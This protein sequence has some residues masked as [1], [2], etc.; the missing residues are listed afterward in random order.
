MSGTVLSES[1][2]RSAPRRGGRKLKLLLAA[3]AVLAAA[4]TGTWYVAF[5]LPAERA[6][7]AFET[8]A[9]GVEQQQSGDLEAAIRSF[10]AA[11]RLDADNSRAWLLLGQAHR[12]RASDS[13]EGLKALERASALA[14]T[15][16]PVVREYGFALRQ[17]GRFEKARDVLRRVVA[18]DPTDAAAR[19]ELAQAHLGL[20]GSPE[21]LEAAI[22]ELRTGL[23]LEPGNARARYFLAR[24]L[25]QREQLPEAEREFKLTLSLLA[26]GA[27][28]SPGIMDGFLNNSARWLSFVKS[29]HHY[30]GQI[31]YRSRRDAEA[32]RY[33]AVHEDI[34]RYLEVTREPFR[35]LTVDAND[36]AAR[37][38]LSKIYVRFGFPRSGPDGAAAARRWIPSV[39]EPKGDE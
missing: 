35:M 18:L 11:T 21:N 22:S 17:T 37:A 10:Q 7:A 20:D 6:R 25:F 28:Q 1:E 29:A 27:R 3:L 8:A 13:A 32:A 9:R 2:H 33:R 31:A 14:P 15:E 12:E 26:A 23:D 34:K 30:L 4:G 38:A 5:R 36:P 16:A 39:A 19:V 24:T